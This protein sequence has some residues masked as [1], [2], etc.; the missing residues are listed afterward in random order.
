MP[1]SH[2]HGGSTGALSSRVVGAGDWLLPEGGWA[3]G[4]DGPECASWGANVGA[5]VPPHGRTGKH[6]RESSVGLPPPDVKLQPLGYAYLLRMA[7][8][9]AVRATSAAD[10]V[11][12]FQNEEQKIKDS[13]A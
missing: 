6:L 13:C 1:S 3:W 7:Y 8:A 9:D 12:L 4:R 2:P 11:F 5:G 10:A